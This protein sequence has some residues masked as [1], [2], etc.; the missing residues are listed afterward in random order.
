M[1]LADIRDLQDQF[2]PHAAGKRLD[3]LFPRV[4][5]PEQFVG[6]QSED[7][8]VPLEQDVS[9]IVRQ[10]LEAEGLRVE[11]RGHPQVLHGQVDLESHG[12]TLDLD[13][14]G[15]GAA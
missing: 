15:P 5:V 1:E 3:G 6:L 10:F 2:D 7:Q 4:R 14:V 13:L 11:C 9:G 12:L 8:F